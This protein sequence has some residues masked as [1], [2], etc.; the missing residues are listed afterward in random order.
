MDAM[1]PIRTA[2]ARGL[3]STWSS[4]VVVGATI[5]WVFVE[6]IV[7]VS[8]GY[9]GPF[10]PLG[11]VAAPAPLS[12][13]TDLS[14]SIGILGVG[15][16][17]PLVPIPAALHALWHSIVV[18][19][20]LETIETGRATRWG[21]IRGLRAF[22]VAFAIHLF[23]VAV[24]FMSQ[25]VAGLGGEGLSLILQL[26]ILVLA[27][28]VFAFAPVIAVA[29]GRR[30]LDCLGRSIRAARLPGSGNLTFAGIYVLPW[31][32]IFVATVV[33]GVPGSTLDV[34]PRYSAWVF[35]VL[36]GLVHAAIQGALA[37]RYLAI[38]HEVPDAPV[39][40]SPPGGGAKSRQGSRQKPQR[41]TRA[42]R[43]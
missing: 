3:A 19:L 2:F 38:T 15:A 22:P 23:G 40:R 16:G 36:M 20:A 34:N 9:P 42:G 39:R 24:L 5:A 8:L 37:M 10:A 30:F 11:H 31:F 26:G 33:G 7:V 13:P 4:S 1:P 32:A 18:G 25:I 17:L 41:S 29:E 27:V 21:A 35:V 43:R 12:T 6:W 28:W 14:V